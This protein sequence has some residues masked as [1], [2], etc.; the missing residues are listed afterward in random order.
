LASAAGVAALL[1]NRQHPAL[2]QALRHPFVLMPAALA[3]WSCV[4]ALHAKFPLLSIGGYYE[5]GQGALWYFDLTVLAACALLVAPRPAV[6]RALALLAGA[7]A[8]A[9]A[10]IKV[11]AWLR[12]DWAL[13]YVSSF[14]G[15]IPLALPFLLLRVP[16]DRWRPV[17]LAV[18]LAAI[19]GVL[20]IADN[21]AAM[22]L[23]ALAGGSYLAIRLARRRWPLLE[24][25]PSAGWSLA[26]VLAAGLL[27]YALL[28]WFEPIQ[29]VASLRSRHLLLEL[30]HE[31]QATDAATL[32]LG[33]GWGHVKEAMFRFATSQGKDPWADPTSGSYWDFL[34][35]DYIHSHNWLSETLYSV[36]IP[37]LLLFLGLHLA[38]PLACDARRR[39][40]ATLL[41][42]MVL[43]MDGMWIQMPASLPFLALALGA[44][45]APD[46]AMPRVAPRMA[47]AL[48]A[49]AA[50]LAAQLGFAVA[51]YRFGTA[52][53]RVMQAYNDP[54]PRS[55]YESF[56]DDF[57]GSDFIASAALR[58]VQEREAERLAKADNPATRAH[59]RAVLDQV[60]SDLAAR[61]PDTGVARFALTALTYYSN[62]AFM[63]SLAW[64]RN[65]RIVDMR[66]WSAWARR[67]LVLAPER[68]DTL[69]PY[70]AWCLV[71]RFYAEIDGVTAAI[72]QRDPEDPVALYYRGAL[73][74]QAND[75]GLREQGRSLIRR[76]L[77]NGAAV[78]LA[79]PK[80]IEDAVG[81]KPSR[82]E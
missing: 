28:R 81:Y 41:A 51:Q 78:L 45:A 55:H 44:L 8:A 17:V 19:A 49:L 71:N 16:A 1:A 30:M 9:V 39:L 52:V 56:P 63:E 42:C 13:I 34:L 79:L 25:W 76:A 27:P 35:R 57:R 82:I 33:S 73:M 6:W 12:D 68:T 50:V 72:L 43:A 67:M 2:V 47:V 46:K 70:L 69:H 11:A 38:I 58:S 36:G 54:T 5:T 65:E 14:Y 59:A 23:L 62:I 61:M 7:I 75:P 32:L 64:L 22:L 74:M 40:E 20:A 60:H 37:G 66:E 31:A 26:A 15:Y 77:D 80:S 24:G 3:L 21:R 4:A 10:A 53:S 18:L 48:P 29:Q